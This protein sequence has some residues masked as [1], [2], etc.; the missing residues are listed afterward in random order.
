MEE[1]ATG[2]KPVNDQVIN[3]KRRFQAGGPLDEPLNT[4]PLFHPNHALLEVKAIFLG[5]VQRCAALQGREE[6]H[7][8]PLP[9]LKWVLDEV[10][11]DYRSKLEP[12]LRSMI[13]PEVVNYVTCHLYEALFFSIKEQDV[14]RAAL[15]LKDFT[16]LCA[17]CIPEFTH[18]HVKSPI[19]ERQRQLLVEA[20]NPLRALLITSL[21]RP[22]CFADAVKELFID[23]PNEHMHRLRQV[24]FFQTFGFC[25]MYNIDDGDSVVV[26][27]G[28]TVPL[29]LRKAKNPLASSVSIVKKLFKRASKGKDP[30]E[31][32][33]HQYWEV[34]GEAF[35]QGVMRGEA[36][37]KVAARTIFLR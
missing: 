22:F 1:I 9:E 7:T 3:Y 17:S 5:P 28:C 11:A 26:I 19:D 6:H 16:N 15:N 35:V 14:A 32:Q 27:P 2:W 34:A 36:V 30:D 10:L 24:P 37:G 4:L 8:N 20:L 18:M 33:N 12:K 29:V 31:L 13:L 23:I 21:P 25:R